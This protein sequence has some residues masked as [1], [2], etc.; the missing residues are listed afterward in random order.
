M[1]KLLLKNYY[2]AL[3]AQSVAVQGTQI[4]GE[5]ADNNPRISTAINGDKAYN[6]LL[7]NDTIGLFPKY[8]FYGAINNSST[9]GNSGAGHHCWF[10]SSTAEVKFSDYAPVSNIGNYNLVGTKKSTTIS[11]DETTKTYTMNGLYTITNNNN[12]ELPINEI[13]LG[14][15]IAYLSNSFIITRDLLG[16]NSFILGAKESV[17]FEITI[18]YTIAQP[19]Q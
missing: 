1:E 11:Y 19:L 6:V 17:N 8:F 5:T 14:Y 15:T 12:V 9:G 13:C 4:E 18:K 2:T 10:G 16:E 7:T 3:T